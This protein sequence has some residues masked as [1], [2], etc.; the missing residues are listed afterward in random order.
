MARKSTSAKQA[1]SDRAE[2]DGKVNEEA[3]S[4]QDGTQEGTGSDQGPPK[5]AIKPDPEV[6]FTDPDDEILIEAKKQI[7][8]EKTG[9]QPAA[10]TG[11]DGGEGN[12]GAGPSA[13]STKEPAAAGTRTPMIPK[14]RFDEAV[15]EARAATLEAQ[16]EAEYWRGIAQGMAMAKPTSGSSAGQT[17]PQAGRPGMPQASADP[18][19]RLQQIKAEKRRLRE[20]YD[21]GALSYAD[22]QDKIDALEEEGWSI[23]NQSIQSRG[24]P[25]VPQGGVTLDDLLDEPTA[26]LEQQHPYTLVIPTNDGLGKMRWDYLE[27]EATLQLAR[28]GALSNPNRGPMNVREHLALRTRMAELTDVYGPTWYPDNKP[29]QQGQQPAPALPGQGNAGQR[30]GLT[31]RQQARASKLDLAAGHPPN[32]SDLGASGMSED[33]VTDE[34]LLSMTEDEIAA[35]PSSVRRKISQGSW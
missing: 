26:E 13:G 15:H 9:E 23:R 3:S 27:T 21:D 19:V 30:S 11:D 22:M 28:E 25:Q 4:N 2:K 29:Q 32:V 20:Q 24:A 5:D 1:E 35:L 16:R 17:A 6:I 8:V 12:G 31:T 10:T 33:G 34:R 14:P 18:N 7:E